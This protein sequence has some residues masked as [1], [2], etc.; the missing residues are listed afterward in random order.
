MQAWDAA[1]ELLL[2]HLSELPGSG[3]AGQRILILNDS[4][5]AL[6]CALAELDITPYTDSYLSS[7]ATELNSHG[8]LRPIHR[9]E[10]LTGSYDW[11]LARVPKN[12]SYWED[13]LC[14]VSQ[15]AHPGS[16]LI[17]GYMVKHQA[18]A[19]FALLDKRIGPTRTSLARKKARLIFAD[20]ER[21]PSALPAPFE[22]A[23]P[24]LERPLRNLSNL[25][26]RAGLDIGTRFLLE[27]L[28]QGSYGTI[29]DLGCANG[30]IGIAAKKANPS[31][32]IIF[33]DESWMAIESARANYGRFFGDEASFEWTH[34]HEGGKP[35]AADLVLCNPPFHQGNAVGDAIAWQMFREARRALAKGGL[36]RVVGNSH[37]GYQAAL[38]KVFGNCRTVATNRKFVILDAV[39]EA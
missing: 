36:L 28:P 16:R 26:S 29:L 1:D 39:R 3:L 18:R 35:G 34:C 19:S 5:G 6:S 27:Q 24:S 17:C 11:I 38:R 13:L 14:H 20:F 8:R 31:A 23:V 33:S 32:R 10:E 30:V 4:F 22:V 25:F 37:L 21:K 9:L 12:M 2:Q 15:H 7:R